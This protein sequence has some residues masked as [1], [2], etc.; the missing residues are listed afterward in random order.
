MYAATNGGDEMDE[1]DD[2]DD[3][4]CWDELLVP[5]RRRPLH[6]LTRDNVAWW[7]DRSIWLLPALAMLAA[8]LSVVVASAASAA[9]AALVVLSAALIALDSRRPSAARRRRAS[10]SVR[11]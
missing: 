10:W 1:L 8:V 9:S 5:A 7:A 3:D 11:P 4:R 2:L 6:G